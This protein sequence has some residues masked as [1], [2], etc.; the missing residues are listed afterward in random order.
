MVA[1][2]DVSAEDVVVTAGSSAAFVL[3]FLTAFDAGDRV[4]TAVPGYPPYRHTLSALGVK[5]VPM[6]V[7]AATGYQPT[8]D[9]IAAAAERA[10]PL[11][12]VIVASPSNPT[13]TVLPREVLA[14]IAAY[15]AERRIRLISDEIYHGITFGDK[16]GRFANGG[17]R[18]GNDGDAT[19]VLGVDPSRSAIAVSSYS[20]YHC[21][22]GWRLGWLLAR[23]PT[24]RAAV[25]RL[26]QS[27]SAP[28]TLHAPVGRRP[29]HAHGALLRPDVRA[30]LDAHV[31]RYSANARSLTAA[32]DAAGCT[33]LV[34]PGGAFY[35]Y[36]GVG[37]LLEASGEPD[38]G[39]L[40]GRLLADTGVAVTPGDDFDA[41]RGG[42]YVRLSVCGSREDVDDAAAR[43]AK[44]AAQVDGVRRR[45]P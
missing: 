45:S 36:A 37:R 30:G 28:V 4:A 9:H 42:G 3:A 10:G 6:P 5:V 12:G 1:A 43:I 14:D 31:A 19:C 34:P 7:D 8:V 39:A 44:W 26:Q 18:G 27:L 21:M 41:D 38:S 17:A 24:L 13:G 29:P 40:C 33:P 25:E 16:E 35:V 22:T 2:A 23:D 15:C 32:L 20:K 11:A